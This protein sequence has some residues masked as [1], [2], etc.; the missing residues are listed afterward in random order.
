[1]NTLF[2]GITDVLNMGICA[3]RKMYRGQGMR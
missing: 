3:M 2:N 1:M